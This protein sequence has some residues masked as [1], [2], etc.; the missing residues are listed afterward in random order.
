MIDYD[1]TIEKF[2]VDVELYLTKRMENAKDKIE[3]KNIQNTRFQW[4]MIKANPRR[5]INAKYDD[6]RMLSV[7][8]FMRGNDNSVYIAVRDV[9][10]T[11]REIYDARA[12][13]WT[14]LEEISV[15]KFLNAY[16][17]WKY[18]SSTSVFKDFVF[19]FKSAKSFAVH[20]NQKQ[21]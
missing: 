1:A 9:M 10:E 7:D 11:I 12:N 8:G 2:L 13:G 3:A 18:K 4:G 5:Y 20:Y 14:H 15:Q 17:S 19:P 21:K 16:K 6:A